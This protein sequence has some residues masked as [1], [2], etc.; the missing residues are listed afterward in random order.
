MR[1]WRQE[2]V[3][4]AGWFRQ[5]V[6]HGQ[7]AGQIVNRFPQRRPRFFLKAAF[8]KEFCH[9]ELVEVAVSDGP[10]TV[11]EFVN[12]AIE[13]EERAERGRVEEIHQ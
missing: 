1:Q 6:L 3:I 2:R 7:R 4:Q 9:F 11:V 12:V 5:V 8:A 10:A 13:T